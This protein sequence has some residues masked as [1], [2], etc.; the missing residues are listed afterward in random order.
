[1]WYSYRILGKNFKIG[2]ATSSNGINWNRRDK[3]L[4]YQLK[5]ISMI[6]CQNIPAFFNHKNKF[7]SLFNGNNYGKTGV[8]LVEMKYEKKIIFL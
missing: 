4:R 2:Y 5:K 3:E 1:M 6:K 7:F 8:G